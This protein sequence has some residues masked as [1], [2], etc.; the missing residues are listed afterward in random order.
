M[1]GVV[2]CLAVVALLTLWRYERENSTA[3]LLKRLPTQ[4]ATVLHLDVAA[5]RASGLLDVLAGTGA[6]EETDYRNFV[7][8]TGFDYRTDLDS[9]LI[10]FHERETFL[11]L[12][13]RFDW[14]QLRL[15]ARSHRGRCHNSFCRLPGSTPDRI[16]SFFPVTYDVMAMASSS[17]EY[18]ALTMQDRVQQVNPAEVPAD[19]VWLMTSGTRLARASWLPTG[20]RSLASAVTGAESVV[21]SVGPNDD[22]FEARLKVTCASPEEAIRLATELQRVTSLLRSLI[23]RENQVPSDSDLSGVLTKGAFAT[24]G[25]DMVG[26]WPLT[27]EFLAAMGHE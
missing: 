7:R 15:Y 13:G 21:F 20:T 23:R 27:R 25:S 5:I 26:R 4:D 10:A 8:D 18:A 16:I 6:D 11:L 9:A 24:T 2:S 3:K 17:D 14:E 12:R 22:A 1:L 19:P